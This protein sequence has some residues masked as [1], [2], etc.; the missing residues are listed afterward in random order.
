MNLLWS[1]LDIFKKLNHVLGSR[2]NFIP[3][4]ILIEQLN[5]RFDSGV[6]ENFWG[7]S[8][9]TASQKFPWLSSKFPENSCVFQVVDTL[10]RTDRLEKILLYNEASIAV[11][12]HK[13]FGLNT[14]FYP[15]VIRIF[16]VTGISISPYSVFACL[17]GL[18]V[19]ST[20]RQNKQVKSVR[21]NMTWIRLKVLLNL[22]LTCVNKF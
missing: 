20:V 14:S 11:A 18:S 17:K 21:K 19:K 1:N 10:C 16:Y 7:V 2:L 9:T 3:E 15:W 8:W 4:K 5:E 22:R 6:A 12:E 13:N